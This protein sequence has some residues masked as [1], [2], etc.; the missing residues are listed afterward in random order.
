MVLAIDKFYFTPTRSIE[1][2]WDIDIPSCFKQIYPNQ[3]S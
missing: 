2:N 1:I 3:A